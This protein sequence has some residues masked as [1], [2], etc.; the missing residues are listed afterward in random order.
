MGGAVRIESSSVALY[1]RHS[2]T[3]SREVH[4]S[5]R[6]QVR[7]PVS[8]RLTFSTGAADRSRAADGAEAALDDPNLGFLKTFLEFLTGRKIKV[9]AL[10]PA[11]PS[12][13]DIPDPNAARGAR[14]SGFS[15][16]YDYS[17]TRS[18]SEQTQFKAEGVVRTADGREI[19]FALNLSM[20]RHWQENIEFHLRAGDAARPKKD[21]LVLVFEGDAARLTDTKFLFDLDADGE[22]E[23]VSFTA[24][25]SGFLALDRNR[26]G[27]INNGAELFGPASGDGFEELAAHDRDGNGW[28]DES[29]PVFVELRIYAQDAEGQDRLYTLAE[30]DVG[31][32]YLGRATT[33]FELNNDRNEPNGAVRTSGVYLKESGGA[34]ALQQLDL[35]V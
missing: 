11:P 21:P 34:G 33:P 26:D 18:E 30:K 1:S 19:A 7:P 2:L 29:D 31:A 23:S 15:L 22:D 20:A 8:D 27:V 12:P 10:P 6:V 4:E 5:L 25:G 28:I 35:S 16:E 32:L 24:P 17:E 9:F 3:Q 13:P 14:A